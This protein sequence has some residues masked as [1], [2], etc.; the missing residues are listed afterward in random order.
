MTTDLVLHRCN[1]GTEFYRREPST[2]LHIINENHENNCY[3]LVPNAKVRNV[4]DAGGN[5]GI[6][7]I[8]AAKTFPQASIVTVEPDA[9]NVAVMKANCELHG[10]KLTLCQKALY[11]HSNGVRFISCQNALSC[12]DPAS[13]TIMPSISLE[14]LLADMPCVDI[15]KLDIEG[16]EIPALLETRQEV[17]RKIS[18]IVG[19]YHNAHLPQWGEW[20]R[21]LA[22]IYDMTIIAQ[23]YPDTASN[24]GF[25]VGNLRRQ[26]VTTVSLW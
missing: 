4:V 26:E 12:V 7:T 3:G 24:I 11:S 10:V 18:V 16:S 8:R 17:L 5:I 25:F 15:L 13:D 22:T 19:E 20:V 23:R 14:D 1:D 9:A 6:F 2:D 21:Y